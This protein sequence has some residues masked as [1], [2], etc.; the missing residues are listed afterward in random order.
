MN[1]PELPD[2]FIC[3]YCLPMILALNMSLSTMP[4]SV[5][6][7]FCGRSPKY[8]RRNVVAWVSVPVSS[9][10]SWRTQAVERSCHNYM[11]RQRLRNTFLAKNN[12]RVSAWHVRLHGAVPHDQVHQVIERR[13]M[14]L[15]VLVLRSVGD[16]AP[17]L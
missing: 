16:N 11:D 3:Q 7:V 8:I 4:D 15:S 10:L 14:V 12:E 2:Y 6:T 1:T 13:L 17:A 9:L 5:L